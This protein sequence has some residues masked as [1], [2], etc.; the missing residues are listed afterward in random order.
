MEG[1]GGMITCCPD[2]TVPARGLVRW[3]IGQAAGEAGR[4]AAKAAI[5]E[6]SRGAAQERIALRYMAHDVLPGAGTAG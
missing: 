1:R 2:A 6:V 3:R 4:T 5:P